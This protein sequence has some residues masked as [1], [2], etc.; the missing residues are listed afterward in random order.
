MRIADLLHTYAGM[1]LTQSFL[2]A[3]VASALVDMTIQVWRI[4]G[5]L[6]RQRLRFGVIL[7]AA[8]SFPVYQLVDPE[9]GAVPRR[10]SALFDS[11]QWLDMEPFGVALRVPFLALL[12]VS[13]LV[14]VFQ[15]LVPVALHLLEREDAALAEPFPGDQAVVSWALAAL[16]EP[17]PRVAL[18]DDED[19]VLFS[20]GGRKAAIYISTGLLRSLSREQV[21]AALAHE[22]A[23][24]ARSKRPLL[25]L[26]FAVRALLFFNPVALLEFR[27]AVRGEEKICDD[28]AV[29][30]THD[31]GALAETLKRF[32]ARPGDGDPASRPPAG[33]VGLE[34]Y[35]RNLQLESRVARLEREGGREPGGAWLPATL[36]FSAAAAMNFFVV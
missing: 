11:G 27:R 4:D 17:R 28:V 18:V 31:P 14:F 23:H 5:P 34:D 19:L 20:T 10:T 12:G 8:V 2:H 13:A 1:Y 3:L 29:S 35:S 7:Y 36:A 25:V 9:R 30:L 32:Y 33:R 22:A 15:E 16:P 26:V 24:I 21:R 6:S